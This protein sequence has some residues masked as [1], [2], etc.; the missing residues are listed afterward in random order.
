MLKTRLQE[1]AG[2]INLVCFGGGTGLP[3]LL[4]GLKHNPWL[5][6]T[7][8][9]NMFD[10]GGSSGELRDK[11][12]I[13]PPGDIL[14]CLLALSEDD[15]IARK[16]LLKR[17][18]H[19]DHPGHTGGNL[20][21]FALEKVYENYQ[22]SINALAQILSVKGK[23]LPVTLTKATLCGK[24]IDGTI[25]KGETSIDIGV[26]EGKEVNELFLEP[27]AKAS[28]QVLRAISN[29]DIL[30]IGPGSFYTS[31]LPNFLPKGV[32]EAIKSSKAPI[33]FTANLLTEGMGMKGY[34]VK[35]IVSTLEK[36]T[37]RRVNAVIVNKKLPSKEILDKY[38]EERKRPIIGMG[39]S[40]GTKFIRADLWMDTAIARHDSMRLA[41]LIFGTINRLLK[42]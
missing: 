10:T 40:F 3:S 23:V 38:N 36:Y 39:N 16:I 29:A 24:Y 15:T 26:H 42:N 19:R 5:E 17:I 34:T 4:S 13:L 33:I 11:F 37:G 35:K 41:N 7:A 25:Y 12:G 9:V 32:R 18:N 28:S 22:D 14:K 21:L 30:C 6:V 2:K 31:I 27:S 1:K 20:L 8:V